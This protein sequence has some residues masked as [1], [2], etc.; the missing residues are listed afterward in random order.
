MRLAALEGGRAFAL[1]LGDAEYLEVRSSKLS[2]SA[3][4]QSSDTVRRTWVVLYIRAPF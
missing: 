1:G 3:L 2:N 4:E